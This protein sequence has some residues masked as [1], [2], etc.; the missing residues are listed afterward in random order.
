MIILHQTS[1][2]NYQCSH[3]STNI[4]PILSNYI[5]NK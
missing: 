4:L 1:I 3:I 5:S 2:F